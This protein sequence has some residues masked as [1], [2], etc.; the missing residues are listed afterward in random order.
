MC[1]KQTPAQMVS[2][3][4]AERA[5]E[6]AKLDDAMAALQRYA[7]VKGVRRSDV[8]MAAIGLRAIQVRIEKLDADITAIS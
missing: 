6:Q 1:S 4:I 7:R 2:E 8:A 3:L 5:V